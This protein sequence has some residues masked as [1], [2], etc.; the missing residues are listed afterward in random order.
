MIHAYSFK[1]YWSVYIYTFFFSPI[2]NRPKGCRWPADEIRSSESNWPSVSLHSLIL[3]APIKDRENILRPD[4]IRLDIWCQLIY[5]RSIKKKFKRSE[6]DFIRQLHLQF[7]IFV[8]FDVISSGLDKIDTLWTASFPIA[9]VMNITIVLTQN[10]TVKT[11][12][13]NLDASKNMTA[14]FKRLKLNMYFFLSGV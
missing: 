3:S 14:D 4:N 5:S 6:A 12:I 7:N 13:R 9:W 2:K 10:K 11:S 8:Y 1:H